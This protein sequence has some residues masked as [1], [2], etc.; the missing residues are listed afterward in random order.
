MNHQF[1]NQNVIVDMSKLT[2]QQSTTAQNNPN[3]MQTSINARLDQRQTEL[4][5][6]NLPAG[7]RSPPMKV[8]VG[9]RQQ[10]LK[11]AQDEMFKFRCN[12]IGKDHAE[13]EWTLYC[14]WE[15]IWKTAI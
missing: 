8:V 5:E 11:Q 13:K 6:A 3:A 15:N 1:I 12:V 9:I 4:V 10:A 7:A 2:Q 14:A